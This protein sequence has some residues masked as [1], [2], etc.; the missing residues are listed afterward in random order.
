MLLASFITLHITVT[1][2]VVTNNVHRPEARQGYQIWSFILILLY[3]FYHQISG[4]FYTLA[5]GKIN[6]SKSLRVWEGYRT[7]SN[8]E[9]SALNTA[10]NSLEVGHR[11][12]IP[13]RPIAM[14]SPE[15]S[16]KET[17][18][19]PRCSEKLIF[20]TGR[21]TKMN[22]TRAMALWRSLIFIRPNFFPGWCGGCTENSGEMRL[23]GGKA[24]PPL[25]SVWGLEG[26]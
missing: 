23:Q 5:A 15:H 17:S 3:I 22:K 19:E 13:A 9:G 25:Q 16:H 26:I 4:C 2:V 7:P 21:V 14:R 11:S 6:W 24:P 12:F 1:N 8:P 20:G 10:N 18:C